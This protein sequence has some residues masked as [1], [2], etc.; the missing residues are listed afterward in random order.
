MK[1]IVWQNML[2]HL[3]AAHV[4]ALADRG[5]DVTIVGLDELSPER[6]ALGW[7]VPDFGRA[8]AIASPTW[9]QTL[10]L[11]RESGQGVHIL[12][13]WRGMR[14]GKR[15]LAE[16]ESQSACI[17]LLT[18]GCETGGWRGLAR[19]VVYWKD[20]LLHGSRLDFILAMGAQ[21]IS[22]FRQCGYPAEKLYP[23]GYFTER[24]AV[25][26]S[27][28]PRE[29]VFELIYLGHCVERKGLDMAVRALAGL[30]R[31]RWRLSVIGSGPAA[32]SWRHLA[33]RLGIGSRV[34]FSGAL[35]YQD[36]MSRL[37]KSDLL[38]LPSRFDGWGAVV[39]EAL[40]LGVPAM[41]SD[42][43]GAKD[44]LGEAW[45]G[46]IFPSGS[47]G[48]LQTTLEARIAGGRLNR[49]GRQ[50][51]EQWSR[52]LEGDSGAEYI[53]SVIRHVYDGGPRPVAPWMAE[54]ATGVM[55]TA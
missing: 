45:R 33:E 9:Q 15:L 28:T 24:P 16:L 42:A 35:P 47:V 21:G 36:A 18:E 25:S 32:Q 46:E 8:R 7:T 49:E 2:S 40:M 13:G 22:W 29:D 54:S 37:A 44:L 52:C 11:I 39:N 10:M 34:S 12:A 43:C 14:Y 51:I 3:Q 38:L 48:A 23:Y 31:L 4:R 41:C 30:T 5:V 1:V 26:A 50:R 20:A 55:C 17:G 27:S 19:R 6:R 53:L